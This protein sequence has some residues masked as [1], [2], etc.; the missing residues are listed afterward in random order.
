MDWLIVG[1]GNPG[2]KYDNTR[3][4]VGF[5]V[6][7]ILSSQKK[8][9]LKKLKFQSLYGDGDG[10]LL[11]KPQ[12][13][14]NLSGRAVREAASFYKIPVERIL[15]VY[16]DIAL[17]V[18][19]LRLRKNGTDGGHNGIKDI[20]YQLQSDQFPRVKIGVGSKPHPEMDLADWVLS[21][22]SQS[23]K[24]LIDEACLKAA[25]AVEAVLTKGMDNA[26]NL[27]NIS[28]R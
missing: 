12:T 9:P 5:L 2:D 20:V 26:M 22:F 8:I 7:D 28:P 3:H 27:Y 13:F 15:V 11:L 21:Q 17:P 24:K 14:M 1:L 25:D 18:G 6:A 10:I 19:K 16:D 23:E 4:N